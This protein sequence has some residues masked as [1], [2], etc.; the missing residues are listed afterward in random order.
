VLSLDDLD[1]KR[2]C[3]PG[4]LSSPESGTTVIASWAYRVMMP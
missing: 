4:K 2:A 3:D 1:I